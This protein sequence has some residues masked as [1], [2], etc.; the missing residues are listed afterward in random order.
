MTA[1]KSCGQPVRWRRTPAGKSNPLDFD[2]SPAGNVILVEPG[3]CRTLG[4]D[5]LATARRDG[6]QLYLS[7]FATCPQAAKHRRPK[8]G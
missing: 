4:G 1:C 2:P 6:T 7:H 3:G 8:R 5:E